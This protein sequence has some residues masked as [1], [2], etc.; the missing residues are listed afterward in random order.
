MPK[1]YVVQLRS[2][3]W[4]VT[5]DGATQGP[6]VSK[7]AAVSGAIAQAKRDFGMG[8]LAR[9]WVEEPE[10]GGPVVYDSSKMD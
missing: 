5:Q 6:F 8:E 3:Q 4:W 1:E 10:D 2:K 7:A 9:V